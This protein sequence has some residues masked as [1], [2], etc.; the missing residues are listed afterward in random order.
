[1]K[2]RWSDSRRSTFERCRRQFKYKYVDRLPRG[3]PSAGM[4]R[5]KA[6]DAAGDLLLIATCGKT[7]NPKMIVTLANLKWDA[8]HIA[9]QK[10]VPGYPRELADKAIYMGIDGA[11]KLA[12]KGWRLA[13][14]LQSGE[15]LVQMRLEG[16]INGE[17]FLGFTD[18]VVENE[19]GNRAILDRKV[20]ACNNYSLGY[21]RVAPQTAS[22][23]LLAPQ[24]A[25]RI[26]VI[27]HTG[28]L[29]TKPNKLPETTDYIVPL[30]EVDTVDCQERIAFAAMMA[31][32]HADH[33][34]WP[35]AVNGAYESPCSF[36]DFRSECLPE[37]AASKVNGVGE[38]PKHTEKE[39]A[40]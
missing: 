26:G 36:C 25:D 27:T 2:M 18:L 10:A 16:T 19:A 22:Y 20:S 31:E 1:M 21:A 30:Q 8:M 33:D 12:E 35:R 17:E 4:K 5:G 14:D 29:V 7:L 9:I 38:I 23:C 6:A 37:A 28:F 13:Y 11:I 34:F 39:K 24:N 3:E 32:Y 40:A 15:P